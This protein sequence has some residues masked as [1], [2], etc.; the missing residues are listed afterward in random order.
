[1][2]AVGFVPDGD[3][4][5]ARFRG[6]DA[7]LE[8]SLGLMGEA[9]AHS[10]RKFAECRHDLNSEPFAVGPETKAG[11]GDEEN[12]FAVDVVVA[13]LKFF[14]IVSGEHA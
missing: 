3:H 7:R 4:V 13:V 8:L 9:I 5:D 12:F 6:E 2:L 11:V 10:D 1:M 14:R